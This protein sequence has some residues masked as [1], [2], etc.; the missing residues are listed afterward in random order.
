M[1]AGISSRLKAEATVY[2]KLRMAGEV[3]DVPEGVRL[4]LEERDDYGATGSEGGGAS[5][6]ALEEGNDE[7]L[8]SADLAVHVGGLAADVGE[9]ED[10]VVVLLAGDGG[11]EL[12][13]IDAVY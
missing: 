6:S 7:L 10:D 3:A 1:I 8:V 4:A 2:L 11:G 9:V 5:D 12:G 13:G